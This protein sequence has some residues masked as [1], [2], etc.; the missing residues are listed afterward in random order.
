MDPAKF[1]AMRRAI[2]GFEV[3]VTAVRVTRKLSQNKPAADKAGVVAGLVATGNRALAE[4][5]RG[6]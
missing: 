6:A 5:M 4:A 1:D 3:E 2:R